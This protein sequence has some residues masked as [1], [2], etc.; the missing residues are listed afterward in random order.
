MLEQLFEKISSEVLTDEVKLQMS[1]LFESALTEAVKAKEVELEEANRAEIAEF[2]EDMVNQID[3]YLNYFVEEFVTENE[4]VIESHV[5]VKTA[6]KV[7]STFVNIV[8]DFNLELSEEKADN[9]EEIESLKAENN[10]LHNKIM[11]SRKEIDLVKKAAMI[12]EKCAA[13]ETEVEKDRLVQLAETVE[14]EEDVFEGKLDVLVGQIIAERK[15]D[16][17][18]PAKMEESQEEH[19]EPVKQISESIKSYLKY[20]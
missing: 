14:F 5:K 18:A 6:E 9:T 2:K 4:Q 8:N 10:K 20:L 7:L 13:L 19:T 3:E 17:P 12:A 11:E 1:T 15:S 16:E